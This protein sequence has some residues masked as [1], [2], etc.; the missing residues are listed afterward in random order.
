MIRVLFRSAKWLFLGSVTMLL[1]AVLFTCYLLYSETGLNTLVWGIKSSVPNISIGQSYGQ[2]G[3]FFVFKDV[4][5]TDKPTNSDIHIDKIVVKLQGSCVFQ[6]AI[7]INS[8]QVDGVS[9]LVNMPPSKSDD[10]PEE[11]MARLSWPFPIHVDAIDLNHVD[12]NIDGNQLK[13]KHFHSGL[14]FVL[15]RLE[16]K[17]SVLRDADVT[18]SSRQSELQSSSATSHAQSSPSF[19]KLT[20]PNVILPLDIVVPQ[21]NVEHLV[22]HQDQ[23]LTIQS[24]R[25]SGQLVNNIV[26]VKRLDTK[27]ISL[28]SMHLSG[29]VALYDDYET[30]LSVTS[31]W[32]ALEDQQM[33]LVAKGSLNKLNVDMNLSGPTQGRIQGVLSPSQ[34]DFPFSIEASNLKGHWPLT[35]LDLTQFQI[36]TL[37]VGG[38]LTQ[39]KFHGV[40]Q[41]QRDKYPHIDLTLQGQGN[42]ASVEI[43]QL[44]VQTLKGKMSG[45]LKADWRR[46]VD[47]TSELSL[48]NLQLASLVSGISG[49]INGEVISRF[50]MDASSH[51]KVNVSQLNIDGMVQDYPL[52]ISGPLTVASG[53]G[54]VPVELHTQKLTIAH[55][56][57]VI[58]ASG[59]LRD[60]WNLNLKV[61]VTDLAKSI[62]HTRGRVVGSIDFSGPA[63]DPVARI[64]LVAGKIR[65]MSGLKIRQAALK[66]QVHPI[67]SIRGNLD[68]QSSFIRYQ[69]H[70]IAHTLVSLTGST[71]RHQLNMTTV[72]DGGQVDAEI[73]GTLFDDYHRWKGHLNQAGFSQKSM[74][75]SLNKP[76]SVEVN[77]PLKTMTITPHCW[78][79]G[80]ASLCLKSPALIQPDKADAEL[81]IRQF[82]IAAFEPWLPKTVSLSGIAEGHAVLHW[83]KQAAPSVDLDLNLSKGEICQTR[84]HPVVLGWNYA[85][86]SGML[87]HGKFN[88]LATLDV[89]DNGHLQLS[90]EIPDVLAKE[91]IIAG[92]LDV[93]SL[94]LGFLQPYFGDNSAFNGDMSTH[95]KLSGALMHPQMTGE[96]LLDNMRASSEAFPVEVN[97]GQ[98][99]VTFLGYQAVALADVNTPDGVLKLSGNADWQVLDEWSVNSR[100]YGDGLDINLPPMVHLKAI[101][102]MTLAITP[103]QAKITGTIA[104]PVGK[105]VVETL[106]ESAVTVSDDQIILDKKNK[107]G[108]LSQSLPFPIETNLMVSIGDAFQLEAFGLKGDLSG[109]LNIIQKN[110]AP[111]ISGEVSILDGTYQSFGQ[112]LVIKQGRVIFNGAVNK[113]YVSMTAIRN[114][115]NIE[116]NVTAGI[117]VSGPADKPSIQVFSDP[118]MAQANALSYLL[119]GQSLDAESGD[120][121][122]SMTT[123]L[124]GLSLSQ[125]G[126][127]VGEIGQAVGVQDLK[128]DTAGSGDESQVT[129]S[130][131]VLPGLKIQYGVG[132]FNSVGEFTVRYRLMHNLYVEA[133]S[134]LTSTVDLLY[135]FEFN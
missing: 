78:L 12:L 104:L 60:K 74:Q 89:A 109:K 4:H 31:R 13:W 5:Y 57:N 81:V 2:L 70:K 58:T 120:D 82:D 106:P 71:A 67:G 80:R 40:G 1:M 38:T 115:D 129:V 134:G 39:Y 59:V 86:L 24:L 117:K 84:P 27:V 75:V 87:K 100:V 42:L 95:V 44:V 85:R 10:T 113:P 66:G 49:T 90:V 96:L 20:L 119:R 43:Q 93:Q 46:G 41:A 22:Y 133:V 29:K 50:Q 19:Q 45:Q 26:T 88:G 37:V 30:Q 97:D 65:W 52:M 55:G 135:Q 121:D 105:V 103:K 47:V 107:N 72:V 130:G 108:P 17:P 35:G 34:A 111:F 99:K 116:D 61:D 73:T 98:L 68:F 63:K 53:T 94:N 127:L 16:V 23:K 62:P 128:L 21:F 118:A 126:R 69:R 114:P 18:F 101:P 56:A 51:W 83:K 36:G 123:T 124:I 54:D 15:G 6:P 14:S 32:S 64:D 92:S 79:Q 48:T 122:T 132:I 102:D 11:P 25:L 131:Y 7:C 28:G 125:S 9:G 77:L 91:K 3:S 8:L 112:D 76:T 33:N 110:H